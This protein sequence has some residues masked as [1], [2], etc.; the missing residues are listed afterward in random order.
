MEAQRHESMTTFGA[1]FLSYRLNLLDSKGAT[2]T[3]RVA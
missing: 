2:G 3:N 1:T